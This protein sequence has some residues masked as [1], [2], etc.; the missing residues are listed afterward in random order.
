MTVFSNRNSGGETIEIRTKDGFYQNTIPASKAIR[1]IRN[2]ECFLQVD[3]TDRT[4]N[5]NH[6]TDIRAMKGWHYF[7]FG[8]L[9]EL[10]AS[11]LILGNKVEK[12]KFQGKDCLAIKFTY[13]AN[14]IR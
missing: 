14:K 6:C 11:G 1:G 12:V 7:H 13:D 3:G 8:I 5:E 2:G 10:K 9:M 4:P